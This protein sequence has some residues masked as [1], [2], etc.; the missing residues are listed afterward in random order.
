MR[1]SELKRTLENASGEPVTRDVIPGGFSLGA[2]R[3]RP[4][5]R[6][7]T[8]GVAGGEPLELG[9]GAAEVSTSGPGWRVLKNATSAR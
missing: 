7:G 9:H 4:E 5:R 1:I 8:G 3:L 6:S 2:G